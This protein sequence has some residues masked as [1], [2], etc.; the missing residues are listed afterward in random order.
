MWFLCKKAEIAGYVDFL[1]FN[2]QISQNCKYFYYEKIIFKNK[3]SKYIIFRFVFQVQFMVYNFTYAQS[4]TVF[5]GH[6]NAY[7]LFF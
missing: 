7:G 3:N 1:F 5:C 4:H 2:V 6:L